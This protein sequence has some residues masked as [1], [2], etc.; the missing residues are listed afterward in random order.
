MKKLVRVQEDQ[1]DLGKE[2]QALAA[3]QR[4]TERR[5]QTFINAMERRYNGRG[6]NPPKSK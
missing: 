1:R 3:A 6:K 2:M 4:G 5:L